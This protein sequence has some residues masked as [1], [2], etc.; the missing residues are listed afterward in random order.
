MRTECSGG[1]GEERMVPQGP[2]LATPD[3]PRV[4]RALLRARR[5]EPKVAQRRPLRQPN[6]S[7]QGAAARTVFK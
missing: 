1:N 2:Q 4:A 7:H 3:P 6:A 5:L